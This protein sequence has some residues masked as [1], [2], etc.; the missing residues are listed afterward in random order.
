M[1]GLDFALRKIID[2]SRL[3]VHGPDFGYSIHKKKFL[4]RTKDLFKS[5]T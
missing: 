4:G 2:L 3:L 1:F 5:I